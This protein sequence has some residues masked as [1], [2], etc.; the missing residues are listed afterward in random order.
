MLGN[1]EYNL[2]INTD[3]TDSRGGCKALSLQK[4]RGFQL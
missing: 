4:S 2:V 3:S 1:Y